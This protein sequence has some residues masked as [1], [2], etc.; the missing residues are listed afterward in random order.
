MTHKKCGRC[1]EASDWGAGTTCPQCGNSVSPPGTGAVLLKVAIFGPL[2]LMA[3]YVF[4]P[5]QSALDDMQ[6]RAN[7]RATQTQSDQGPRDQNERAQI[8]REGLP[9]LRGDAWRYS[10]YVDELT[11]KSAKT[12]MRQSQNTLSFSSPYRGEQRGTLMVRQHPRYG[13]DVIVQIE[14]GQIICS[15][16]GCTV[17]VRFDDAEPI[18]Y[19]AVHGEDGDSTAVFIRAAEPFVKR[20]LRSSRV[21]IGMT[22]YRQGAPALIFNVSGLDWDY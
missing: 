17:G 8:A 5:L 22:Y 14:K 12:A 6:S 9:F 2:L 13:L 21:V 18:N 7:E 19:R 15:V 10:S 11:G 4:S 1:G 20:L 16:T 3:Y